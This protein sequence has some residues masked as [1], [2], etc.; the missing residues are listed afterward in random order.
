[1]QEIYEYEKKHLD[2]LR[3]HAAECCLFLKRNND[4]P[5]RETG[6]LALYGKGAR[7]TLKGGT[8]SG[9][10]NSHYF[11]T[12]EE[13]V[14]EAGFEITTKEWLDAYDRKFKEAQEVHARRVI[15]NAKE[16]NVSLFDEAISSTMD[17]P[18]FE[19]PLKGEGE[20]AIYVV[21]RTC[22]EGADRRAEKG[23]LFLT[24]SEKRDIQL[25]QKQYKKFLLVLNVGGPIDL[26]EANE[27]KNILLLSQLGSAT[28]YALADILLGK[29]NPSGKLTTS[30]TK[31]EDYPKIGDVGAWNE[32]RYKEGIYVGY[33]YFDSARV[34]AKYP[35]GFGLSYTDFEIK[36][37]SIRVEGEKICLFADV[38]NIGNYK[39]KEVVQLYLSKPWGRLDQPYQEL[40]AFVKTKELQQGEKTSVELI[41]NLS[42]MAGYDSEK[43]AYILEKGEYLLRLGNSSVNT[44]EV[45]VLKMKEDFITYQVKNVTGRTDFEDWKPLE[46][47]GEEK[48]AILSKTMTEKSTAS[49]HMEKL[50]PI[51]CFEIELGDIPKKIACYEPEEKI[52][53]LVKELSDAEL[54]SLNVGYY[55]P[56]AEGIFGNSAS[57]VAGAAGETAH[58]ISLQT[59]RPYIMADGPAGLRLSK[60][61]I[62]TEKGVEAIGSL[63]PESVVKIFEI[64]D[65]EASVEKEDIVEKSTTK[66]DEKEGFSE[67]QIKHQYA[68]AIPIGTAL[69]QSWNLEYAEK[70]GDIVGDEAER[71]NVDYWLAP[72]LNIHRNI[73]CGRNFEYYS[74]DPLISG[75]FAAAITKGVQAHHGKYTT[76]KHYAANNQETNRHDSNSIVSERALR[77]IYL[78]GFAICIKESHPKAVMTSYNLINGIHTCCDRR[79]IHDVL[80]C[81]FGHKGIVMTDWLVHGI[82]IKDD[83]KYEDPSASEVAATGTELMMPGEKTDVADILNA[84]KE[85][86]VSRKQLEIN[87]SRL[88]A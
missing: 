81:E 12:I 15:C 77:E 9:E 69:A 13:A 64:A 38:K 35:F 84:L 14:E 5:L 25:L 43:Q 18:E 21:S 29:A 70:C 53:P 62:E 26:E 67:E 42:E 56:N 4:F 65:M 11:I 79:L 31:W 39:G 3:N 51:P 44:K 63:L 48:R 75:K 30:W 37:T 52:N 32:T 50:L 49:E 80:R 45:A 27:S 71:F 54:A 88:L 36:K 55:N 78:K 28:G 57:L 87:A 86:K 73:L 33:R 82:A 24:D 72:A 76:I 59:Y 16:K 83:H 41:F 68:S 20:C 34:K 40:C 2:V 6:K 22:G 61:Y 47:V 46:V 17:E 10:V 74:E 8:G 66:D 19:L 85:G 1:M 58:N 23:D 60:D 7:N